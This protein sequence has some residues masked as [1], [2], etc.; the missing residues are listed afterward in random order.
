MSD[1]NNINIAVIGEKDIILPFKAIGFAVFYDT[2]AD[3]IIKRCKQLAERDCQ[4][5]LITEKE[6]EKVGEY[7]DSRMAVPYPIIMTI[8][9][10]ITNSGYGIKRLEKNIEKAIG[11]KTGENI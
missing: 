8:P 11:Q 3:G 2:E 4:I 10:G 6:A 5:I 9:D 1:F 7:L